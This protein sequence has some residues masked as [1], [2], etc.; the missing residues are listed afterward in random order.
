MRPLDSPDSDYRAARR[1][2]SV[3]DRGGLTRRRFLQATLG[4]AASLAIF[5]SPL[6]RGLGALAAAATPLGP[7]QGVLVVILLGGGCDGFNMVVPASDP[8]YYAARGSIAVPA[9]SVL[10]LADGF[11]MHPALPKIHQRYQAGQV[12]CVMGVGYP[13]PDLSHFNSMAYWMSGQP[14]LQGVPTSGW[15]GRW[16]DTLGDAS[17]LESV[18]IDD[19]VPLHLVGDTTVA[20]ALPTSLDSAF[21]AVV[22]DPADPAMFAALDA[23]AAAPTGLGSW[24]DLVTFNSSR[25]MAMGRTV[26]PLY[27]PALPSSSDLST[28]LALAARLINANLGVR[29]IGVEWNGDFDVH[30]DEVTRFGPL[31]TSLDDGVDTF[32]S[33]LDPARSDTVTLM[34]FSEFGR[35]VQANESG[36]D[37]GTASTL[38]VIGANVAGGLK[39]E[40]PS[41]SALDPNGNAV[42]T[43][44]FRSVYATV[45][46]DWLGGDP[47]A[48]LGGSFPSLPL[49]ALP[50]G[51]APAPTPGAPGVTGMATGPGYFLATADGA[52]YGFGRNLRTPATGGAPA[53]ALMAQPGGGGVWLARRDGTV[54]AAGG[55]PFLGDLGGY[56]LDAPIVGATA[57]PTGRGYWL[58]GQDGG[59]FSFGDA[60]FHG[61]TGGIRLAQPVVGMAATPSGGGYWLVASDGGIFS[62]GDAAFHGSTGG[63]RLA[64]PIIAMAAT[65]SGRGYLLA[66]SDGGIFAFGDGSF[67]GGLGGHPLTQPVVALAG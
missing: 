62:F 5:D 11:G 30:G 4:G 67:Q 58:L 64:Q 54:V 44:D 66:A 41:L 31:M 6:G 32:Y 12:A 37:H 39:G 23:M 10:P 14:G 57:T 51:T 20:T 63:I 27:S 2:L 8:A 61:S 46:S 40:P 26:S 24:G 36:T 25:S 59:I 45:L 1:R 42:M 21:G 49:F 18:A 35:R 17:G 52:V 55:A 28:R 65:A 60:A 29:V 47:E 13:N 15:L 38:L 53:A 22:N 19:T 43:T 16:V 3:P 33:T 50:P 56:R 9:S 34:T 7:T 48:V